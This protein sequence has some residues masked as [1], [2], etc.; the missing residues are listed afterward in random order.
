MA[1]LL[2]YSLRV[3]Q[4]CEYCERSEVAEVGSQ[5]QS[6]SGG[7]ESG[8]EDDSD[9][10]GD[11]DSDSNAEAGAEPAI[12]VFRD[13]RKLY[14]WQGRQKELLRRFRESIKED[15]NPKSQQQA[16]LEFYESLIFQHVRGDTFK[17]AILHFLAVLG[18]NEETR[19]LREANDFSYMLAG[20]VY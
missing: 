4:S 18:I 11:G 19:R 5:Q 12:D 10:D 1:R 13:A 20:M 2:C 16:L 3:L 8:T 15:W 6:N 17:S 7:E 9:S 14:P